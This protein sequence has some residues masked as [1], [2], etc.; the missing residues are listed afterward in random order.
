MKYLKALFV[1]TAAVSGLIP[2]AAHAQQA[3]QLDEIVVTAQRRSER[4]QDVP[5]SVTAVTAAEMKAVGITTT[6]DLSLVTPGLRMTQSGGYLQPS[7]RGVTTNRPVPTE[8]ANIATYVDGVYIANTLG[9]LMQLPDIQQVEVL[10]G[11]QG[12]LFGRNATGGAILVTSRAPD[13]SE[14]TGEVTVGV[15][16]FNTHLLHSFVSVPVVQDKVAASLTAYVEDTS[17]WQRN[18][19]NGGRRGDAPATTIMF[20]GKLRFLPWDGAD[21]TLSGLFSRMEDRSSIKQTDF[22]G[23]NSLAALGPLFGVPNVIVSSEPNTFAMNVDNRITPV[24]KML[25]L[26]GQIEA[27]P[28][29]LTTTT[30]YNTASTHLI[31]DADGT[32]LDFGQVTFDTK[33]STFSQELLYTT[34]QLGRFRA[35]VGAFYFTS[36]GG[37]DPLVFPG[38][39]IW[40]KDKGKSF[41]VFG[42]GTYNITDQLEL[43]AGLRYSHE[44]KEALASTNPTALVNPGYTFDQEKT[45]NSVT[46]RVS[47]LYRATPDTNLYATFSK[48]FKSGQ[49]NTPQF[50]PIPADPEKVTAYEVGVKS[51]LT[52]TLSLNAAGFYNDY[53]DLQVTSIQQVGLAF[54][55]VLSNA[56]T[57]EIYGVEVGGAWNP[58]D[59]LRLSFGGAW[60]HARYKDYE[61]ASVNIPS[62]PAGFVTVPT[63]VSGNKMIRTPTWSANLTAQ[64]TWDTAMGDVELSA[65]AFYSSK[66]FFEEGNRVAQPG[67]ENINLSLAWRPS[68]AEGLEL[69]AYVRNLTNQ[70][71]IA[72]YTGGTSHET[73]VYLPPRLFG[74]EASYNF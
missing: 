70:H 6:R 1:S 67:Y 42:E 47:L 18:L 25:S 60:T 7:I 15:S 9:A 72:N 53:K 5:L 56:A 38:T 13:L 48:G 43:T 59:A 29:T 32:A 68:D 44:K 49:F 28:G 37:L 52:P 31:V 65:I 34:N 71:V 36:N 12:T 3:N 50:Q 26:R 41:A 10:K 16:S 27:G 51:R 62:P 66:I 21:F 58:I 63:D 35:T 4:L 30:A 45:W 20:R 14:V 17:G 69:K 19:L 54:T 46:P 33:F 23:V 73:V 24:T 22:G 57:A 64:Y 2:F 55:S 61:N 39:K 74:V 40:T 8:E 11:P